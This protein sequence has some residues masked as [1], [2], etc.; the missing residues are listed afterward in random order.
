MRA[1]GA[2]LSCLFVQFLKGS[3]T[4][5]LETLKR[6]EIPVIRTEKVK[7]FIPD[8]SDEELCFCK[9]NHL[10]CFEQ[11]CDAVSQTSY[12]CVVLDEALDAIQTGM[13]DEE[14]LIEFI[15]SCRGRTEIILTGRDPSTKLLSLADYITIMT[16]IRH[17]FEKGVT[18]RM[19]IER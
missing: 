10:H 4:S 9:E 15:M 14:K 8:M 1:Y 16:G 17:P 11:V 19:G 2:G 18:A 7:K 6:L 13:L 5:E 3:Y 12:D